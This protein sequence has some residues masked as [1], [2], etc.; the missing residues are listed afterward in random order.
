M[1]NPSQGLSKPAKKQAEK[2]NPLIATAMIIAAWRA[3]E[4]QATN[5]LYQDPIAD[6]FLDEAIKEKAQKAASVLP[7]S[8]EMIKL[9]TKY[10]DDNLKE[11][12]Q[13]GDKQVVLLG[14]GLD[15]RASRFAKEGVNYFE[16]DAP[17]LLKFKEE[18]FK[19]FSNN[20]KNRV[21]YIPGDYIQ[22]NV[23]ELLQKN[24]CDP[25][26]PTHFIWEGNLFYLPKEAAKNVFR[27]LKKSFHNFTISFDYVSDRVIKKELDYPGAKG[28]VEWFEKMGAPWITGFNHIEEL[29]SQVGLSI[30]EAIPTQTLRVLYGRNTEKD[31]PLFQNYSV[32]TLS[33]SYQVSRL[34]S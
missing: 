14:S 30:V 28:F 32:C 11:C 9:R 2:I 25:Q 22:E 34:N 15:T 20:H 6:K 29:S 5:P 19:N 12:L 26:L 13:V 4:N 33:N 21:K 31:R 1:S 16:I 23:I 10:F 8:V 27:K 3:Q 18:I 17:V 7:A 24:E